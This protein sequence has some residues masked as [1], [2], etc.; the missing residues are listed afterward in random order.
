MVTK[1]TPQAD[2]NK[3]EETEAPQADENGLYQMIANS[4]NPVAV[5]KGNLATAESLGWKHK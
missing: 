5:N 4:G 3:V 2:E 1:K